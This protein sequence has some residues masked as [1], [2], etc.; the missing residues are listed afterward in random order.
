MPRGV[1]VG[2]SRRG[3]ALVRRTSLG[4]GMARCSRERTPA[5]QASS[6][7]TT[8]VYKRGRASSR[9]GPSDEC[10]RRRGRRGETRGRRGDLLWRRGEGIESSATRASLPQ[11][12]LCP[13][14]GQRRR[15]A[16]E[17][18]PVGLMMMMNC[19]FLWSSSRPGARWRTDPPARGTNKNATKPA[20][21]VPLASARQ[22]PENQKENQAGHSSE[23]AVEGPFFF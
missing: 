18:D 19:T 7:P 14:R 9:F 6:R 1:V 13:Y 15:N 20:H 23:R 16:R 3:A 17:T 5:S 22:H 11:C 4:G 12:A 21:A 10:G 8:C 2:L